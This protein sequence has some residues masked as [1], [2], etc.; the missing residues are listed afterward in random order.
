MSAAVTKLTKSFILFEARD[1]LFPSNI[2]PFNSSSARVLPQTVS[3]THKLAAAQ[4]NKLLMLA[5]LPVLAA[6]VDQG[7]KMLLVH[8]QSYAG[9]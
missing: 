9:T 3:D 7:G 5:A 4:H 8:S 2:Y 6:V 1:V